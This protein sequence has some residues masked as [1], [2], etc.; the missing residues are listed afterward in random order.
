MAIV[1][2]TGAASGFGELTS[3]AFARRGDTVYASMRNPDQEHQL[4]LI[5]KEKSLNIHILRLDVK[6]EDS[7]NEAVQEIHR[8]ESTLDI[9][10]NNAGIHIPG[11]LEDMPE[12]DIHNVMDTNFFGVINVCRAVLPLMR[13][14]GSGRIIM[15]SSVGAMIGRANDS[16]YCASKSALEAMSEAMRYEVA[17]FGIHVSVLQPGVFQTEIG[18]KYNVSADYPPDSP[19]RKLVDFRIAEVKASCERGDDP[20]RIA[21]LVLEIA[22]AEQPRFRYPAGEQAE[23]FL[24]SLAAM[25]EEEREAF[26]RKAAKLD[27]WLSGDKTAPGA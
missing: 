24:P 27:W 17:R 14:Q 16:I 15:L 26:I 10:V 12:A 2:I 23:L 1:L 22:D 3:L 25:S 11:A 5:A 6:D 8:R 18:N 20:D 9:L 4:S 7:I 19:Y 13:E 21:Q